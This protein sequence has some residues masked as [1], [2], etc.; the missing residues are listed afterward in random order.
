[1]KIIISLSFL[2]TI[3]L[4]FT[5]CGQ[6]VQ[7]PLYTWGNYVNS[8]ADYGMRGHEKEVTEKHLAELEK[9]II[10]SESNKQ[11][12]APG[13]YAEYAQILFESNEKVKAKEYFLLE[14]KTYVESTQFIDRVLL[15]LYGEE[16]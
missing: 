12:V 4:L 9:I 14:K 6:S 5:G 2:V 16:K 3:V 1:M 13:L 15:K 7:A 10:E 11:R 8:S